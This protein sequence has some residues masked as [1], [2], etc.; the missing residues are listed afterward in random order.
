MDDEVQGSITPRA[1]DNEDLLQAFVAKG[2]YAAAASLK[3]KQEAAALAGSAPAT[4]RAPATPLAAQGSVLPHAKENGEK[5][6][7]IDGPLAN[8][9]ALKPHGSHPE[10]P[11]KKQ[12]KPDATNNP[13]CED[14]NA[15]VK[16]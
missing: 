1:R 12:P 2:D 3:A 10:A 13:R 7:A 14:C 5:Q 16:P 6:E 15:F 4:P 9:R 8:T 11:P